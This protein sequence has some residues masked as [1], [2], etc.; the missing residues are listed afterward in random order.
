M[1]LQK[2]KQKLHEQKK[3]IG[4][5]GGSLTIKE[6]DE[7]EHNVSAHINPRGWDIEISVKKGYNPLE[8][9]RAK[10]YARIK[11]IKED[12]SLERLLSD[13]GVSHECAHWELAF[14]SGYGCPYDIYNH[15][16]ILEAVKS[17]LPRDKQVHASYVTNAFEDMI[18]NPRCREF[19]GDHSGQV[20]FWDSEGIALKAKDQKH[21]SP[22]YEAFVKLNLYLWGDNIDYSLLKEYFS[23]DKK[24][25]NAIKKTIKDLVLTGN[26]VL[27]QQGTRQLFQKQRWPEMARTFARDLA[28]LLEQSQNERLSSYKPQQ[29]G[30]D[31][32]EQKSGNGIEEKFGTREGTEEIA[33]GRYSKEE[34]L[35]SNIASHDQ[36]DSLYRR[37]ARDI[38]VKVEAISREQSLAITPLTFRAFDFEKDDPARIKSSKIILTD[39]GIALA[40]PDIPLTIEYREKV[41]RKSFP[42][43][44]LVVLDN[45]GSM[46]EGI[47]GDAG[48]DN[49]I[50]W[51]DNSKYHFA[52]LGFYGIE[53]FLQ[54]QGIAQYIGHGLSLFSN[55]TRYKEEG[56]QKLADVRKLALAPEFGNTH[57]DAGVLIQALKGKESFVLSLSDGEIGNWSSEKD[58]FKELAEKNY[59]A[60]IQIGGRTAFTNDLESWSQPVFYV[61]SGNDLSKLMV[62]IAGQT[63]RRFTKQ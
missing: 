13:V 8:R 31:K 14:D 58:K 57:L 5:V 42:D 59:F 20:L 4:L 27:T 43:F 23:E 1:D 46:A 11:K 6:Y 3:R 30:D 55:S 21:F 50:P 9:K 54:R 56:F 53:N 60:H 39:K 34:K 45:S 26:I 36:L 52:L 44:K 49:F 29:N 25:D 2:I 37:L 40:Y 47:N 22:F 16:K 63:Y 18:I 17:A 28:E 24:V 15:D 19:N 62:D 48:N 10:A 51:G 41:Q 35:S 33:F 7:A 12:E 61:A 38:T 32:K